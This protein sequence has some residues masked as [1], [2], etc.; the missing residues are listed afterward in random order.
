MMGTFIGFPIV[1]SLSTQIQDTIHRIYHKPP[2]SQHSQLTQDT[3][4]NMANT[5]IDSNFIGVAER[6]NS[7]PWAMKLIHLAARTSKG[8]YH[9]IIRKVA[10]GLSDD[11]F[12]R[13]ADYLSKMYLV[14]RDKP[15]LGI[16]LE[17]ELAARLKEYIRLTRT[18]SPSAHQEIGMQLEVEMVD[19]S[20]DVCVIDF[21]KSI[22]V[23]G[24]AFT[25][26]NLG[27]NI[28]RKAIHGI[29][30]KLTPAMDDKQLLMLCDYFE[31]ML[32][33]T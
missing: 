12:K 27:V 30:H 18:E 32:I 20:L 25:V 15:Y 33:Q 29:I 7:K 2:A 4:I 11:Q 28:V 26:V 5:F 9:M 21:A 10:N 6:L 19:L 3:L 14:V 22:Q 24:F 23:G 1:E 16:V 31:E 13:L 17:D 8:G